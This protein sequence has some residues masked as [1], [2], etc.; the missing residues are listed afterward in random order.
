MNYT[1]RVKKL[2]VLFPILR[3]QDNLSI[4]SACFSLFPQV[5]QTLNY[6][7]MYFSLANAAYR[8]YSF[9][10]I[11]LYHLLDSHTQN[12]F[13]SVCNKN[14]FLRDFQFPLQILV[15]AIFRNLMI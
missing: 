2:E 12:L 3:I 14:Y 15:H 8:H 11:L 13:L 4:L 10:K 9:T 5:L 6:L 7:P 1:V